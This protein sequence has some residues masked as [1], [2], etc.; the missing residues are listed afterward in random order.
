[1]GC[2]VNVDTTI[3]NVEPYATTGKAR[4][5]ITN[6]IHAQHHTLPTGLGTGSRCSTLSILRYNL[7]LQCADWCDRLFTLPA[8]G[9]TQPSVQYV[10]G[11]FSG[12][13]AARAWRW[14]PTPSSAEVKERVDLYLWAFIDCSTVNFTFYSHYF[15]FTRPYIRLN[16]HKKIRIP[17]FILSKYLQCFSRLCCTAQNTS[18]NSTSSFI[19]LKLLIIFFPM[20]YTSVNW[21]SPPAFA[22]LLILFHF[23]R[24]T[25]W[26]YAIWLITQ[27]VGGEGK[28]D[29]GYKEL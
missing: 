14:P 1:M 27:V 19:W 17:T 26:A 3:L 25:T 16:L 4:R 20:P 18:Q 23:L 24:H 5:R 7:R 29:H 21:Q 6:W 13:K 15:I 22:K 10:P 9:P 28:I 11:L 8:L 2:A 12:R